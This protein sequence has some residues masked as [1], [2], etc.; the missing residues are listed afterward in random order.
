[1]F[2]AGGNLK[3]IAEDIDYNIYKQIMTPQSTN[4]TG[5]GKNLPPISDGNY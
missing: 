4:A 1:M 2:F 5:T 3:F